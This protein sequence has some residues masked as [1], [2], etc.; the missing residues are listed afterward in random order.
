MPKYHWLFVLAGIVVGALL[1]WLVYRTT[2]AASLM[3]HIRAARP[4]WIAVSVVLTYGATYFRA[5]R[6]RAVVQAR[7]MPVTPFWA[8]L[9][10]TDFLDTAI[11][12]K[13]G[14][15]LRAMLLMRHIKERFAPTFAIALVDRLMETSGIFVVVIVTVVAWPLTD[16]LVIPADT[17]GTA[18]DL[19]VSRMLLLLAGGL[20]LGLVT[21]WLAAMVV[22]YGF[23]DAVAR[24]VRRWGGRFSPHWADRIATGVTGFSSRLHLFRTAPHLLHVLFLNTL[25]WSCYLGSIHMVYLAFDLQPPWYAPFLTISFFMMSQLGPNAPAMVGHYHLSVVL[26]Q[27]VFAPT[28]DLITAKA[29]AVVVHLIHFTIML[30]TGLAGLGIE[31][32]TWEG[33]ELR[34]MLRRTLRQEAPTEAATEKKQKVN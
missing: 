13:L 22:F 11:P 16:T 29:V 3:E 28:V 23:G 30:T 6:L 20:L 32:R 19:T 31:L 15:P 12:L 18:S 10:M 21:A 9:Q 2:D 8:A 24:L 34:R 5:V 14:F 1:L 25:F 17:F 33:S 4:G 27:L 7:D 26:A